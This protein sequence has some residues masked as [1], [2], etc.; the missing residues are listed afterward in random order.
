[1]G[2]EKRKHLRVHR[3]DTV[4][5]TAGTYTFSGTSVNVSASGMQVVVE[6]PVSHD[7]VRSI[8]FQFPGSAERVELPCR[9]IRNAKRKD[10]KEQILGIEFL[11]EADAQMLLIEKFIQDIQLKQNDPR[12]LPRTS[13][14]LDDVTV[15]APDL[16]ILSIDDLSTEGLLFSY[17]GTV[18]EGATLALSI[19]VPGDDRR[20][21]LAGTVVYAVENMR[22]DRTA[23]FRFS[24][25]K[26]TEQ[27][28]LRNIIVAF[29]S[30]NAMRDVYHRLQSKAIQP[31]SRISDPI[32]IGKILDSLKA[33]CVRLS[34]LVE[35]SFTV[36][37][38]EVADVDSGTGAFAVRPAG[39]PVMQAVTPGQ[40][41]YFAFYWNRGSH[42]FKTTV[43]SVRDDLLLFLIPPVVFRSDKRSYQ[44]KLMQNDA[45]VTL[46][47]FG[48]SSERHRFEG[49]LID[50]SRRGFLCELLVSSES[51]A[52]FQRGKSLHY[53]LDERLGLGSEGQ[54]RHVKPLPSRD[55]VA[56]QIGVE[57]GI[58]RSAG[59]HRRISVKK[60]EEG[61]K[62]PGGRV[63]PA[64]GIESL[65]VRFPNRAGHEICA[66]VN[67]TNPH[68][69]APVVIIPSAY[70]KK[71]E[72]FSPLVATLLASFW[73]Q[74]KEIVTLRYDGINRPGE[75]HQDEAHPRRGYE[76]L[77]YRI[78]QGLD[79]LQAALDF[80]RG[81][82][83]FIAEKVIIVSFSM[84]AI[85]ARRL[86][87]REEAGGV[88]YWI[89][90]MGV[91]AA[92]TTLRYILGGIDIISNYRLGIPNGIIGL[93]GHLMDM[94]IVAADVVEKKYAF[95]TDA[96]LD[97]SRIAI[98][99]LWIYGLYDKWVDMDEIKDLMSVKAAGSR[100]ILE[101]PTGHNLRTSDDAIQTFKLITSAIH[102]KIHGERIV[103]RDPW[104]EE[105]M[106]LMTAERERLQ[107][108]AAPPPTEYW[109]GYLIGNERNTV[110]YDF[111]R[112]IEEFTD[113]LR[114][115]AESLELKERETIADLGCGTG[116]FLEALLESI[117]RR[118]N[119][120]SAYEITAV[121]LVQEALDKARA[122]CERTLAANPPLGTISFR[123]V[124]KNLEPNRLIPVLRF[125]ESETPVLDSLRNRIEGL[126]S[127][128]LDRLIDRAS[129][130]LYT[131]MRGAPPVG[132]RINRLRSTLDPVDLQAVLEFNRAARF[133]QGTIEASDIKP[134]RRSESLSGQTLRT[135][136]LL[137]ETLSFGDCD[138]A[139]TLDFPDGSF[140]K[141][142]A[143]LFISYLFNPDY[144]IAECHRMLA[145]GGTLLVSSMKPDS[146]ISLM[147]TNYI[148]KAQDSSCAGDEA[149]NDDG[150]VNGARAMLNEAAGLFEL[151]EDGFFK[152]YTPEE[153]R[154]LLSGAGFGEI[155]VFPSMGTPPQAYIATAKKRLT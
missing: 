56:L 147:F 106:R 152:F 85:D 140:T 96:R 127:A 26:E 115:Q 153:L 80:V 49:S 39:E 31:E 94:D 61:K 53:A 110:G 104:K 87:S 3:R 143:S 29:S 128:M 5:L 10:G 75:S 101:I 155:R 20:L 111:Y 59:V 92:Q 107:N 135:G 2:S 40:T 74:G 21:R 70:G 136:V 35:G 146:D 13:C 73:S 113:F 142:V 125:I 93:L 77:S 16:H 81:N 72:A 7:S 54:I 4:E 25:L 19:G 134:D 132:E 83:Y 36:L 34:T 45:R 47:V 62:S 8:A 58:G 84:S 150:G 145:P 79:D 52:L 48:E 41:A 30:G 151:E 129:P 11:Y 130:G 37:E 23:G 78:S 144:A 95:L 119:R 76:M 116:I 118:G 55:G 148:R 89:S 117:A 133:L 22:G 68:V 27:S 17:S 149:R 138:S 88:D 15:D 121:D 1:M 60:W 43:A 51:L 122:K 9:L 67:A 44:R 114:T 63:G 99:V 50:I 18:T 57:A 32:R 108:R 28:R 103:A 100:E 124:Q 6:M 69:K 137:F 141:I 86:L 109:R 65:P 24:G 66:F 42:Y 97:M 33:E 46:D 38:H 131:V 102:E 12:Q 120:F 82:P 91:P 14:R 105:M 154:D 139:I 64:R 90:C 71:K 112:N 98:P 123:Y 126:S